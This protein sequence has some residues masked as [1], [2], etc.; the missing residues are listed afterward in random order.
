MSNIDL[1]FT[2]LL[3]RELTLNASHISQGSKSH[4]FIR[5]L[6]KNKSEEDTSFPRF[7]E[8]DF[9]SGSYA[10]YT[11]IHPLD[12]IDVMMVIDG[13]GLVVIDA[14]VIRDFEVRGSG[15]DKNPVL[16][17]LGMNRLLSSRKIM[18]LFHSALQKS[19]PDSSIKKHGQA[20]NVYL[21]SYEM[22]I[23]IVPCFHIIPRDGTQDFYY[24]PKGNDS[25]EWIKTNP[26]ID[27]RISNEFHTKH[28][29]LFRGIIRL[30][31][32]WNKVFNAERLQSYHLETVAWTVFDTYKGSISSIEDAL[33]HF[34]LNSSSVL[35][36]AC[37]DRTKLGDPVDKYLSNTDRNLSI[38]KVDE[39]IN[40]LKS[41]YSHA[42]S[43]ESIRLGAWKK[44][45]GDKFIY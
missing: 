4:N 32:Y 3:E 24:I 28:N 42:Q 33:A 43:N 20:I 39:T 10:R 6:L 34:F 5:D 31:K 38:M 14:G 11:K 29:E 41:A 23:D 1:A 19:H 16:Q 18:E 40:I 8:G 9:L 22:G 13:S 35:C 26:K 21:N 44:I 15:E 2:N 12:D 30:L 7:V 37:P 27:A 25:D 45:F 36:I 17:Y